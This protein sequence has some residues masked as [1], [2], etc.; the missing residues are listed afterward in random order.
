MGA[1][2]TQ[3]LRLY[4]ESDGARFFPLSSRPRLSLIPLCVFQKLCFYF[5]SPLALF[6]GPAA[7]VR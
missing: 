5:P 6:L 7:R 2:I 4:A 3:L 1:I